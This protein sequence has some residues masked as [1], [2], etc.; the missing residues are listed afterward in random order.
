MEQ[1]NDDDVADRLGTVL[2]GAVERLRRVSGGASRI[3][4]SFD[5][6]ASDG[7]RRPLILQQERGEHITHGSRVLVEADLLKAAS[8][9]GVPVPKVVAAGGRLDPGWLVV[10]RL[11]GESIPRKLLRDPEWVAAR[12]ALT[13]QCGAALAAIHR[14]D[15]DTIG[16]LPHHDP[17][18]DPLPVLDELGEI[19]PTLGLGARWLAINRLPTDRR[20][21]VHGDFRMG[22]LLVG[23]EGLRAV[24]DWELAH[25]GD[26]AED[27]GWL[28]S[29]AWRFGGVGR[30]GGFGHLPAL[31]ESY[32]AA[33]GVAIDTDRIRWWEAYAAVKWAV[34]C[35][36][37][38][39][40][41]LRG[42]T[43]SM[44]LA[45]IGRR[46]C[47]SEWDLLILL[48]MTPGVS[49]S[50]EPDVDAF[51]TVVAPFGRP[52]AGEL[53][54]AVREHL[55]AAMEGSEGDRARFEA[56]I[57][58]NILRV[59]ERELVLGPA[60]A[61]AHSDRLAALGFTGDAALAASIR[62][63]DFDHDLLE[64]GHALAASTREQLLVANPSYLSDSGA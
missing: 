42:A 33:G 56:R 2:G 41:H 25:V 5:L 23:P 53:V 30:V 35:A 61:K 26:P 46:V 4:S 8:R 7:T 58:R 3:T 43:R 19:R 31:L 13:G 6:V 48:G 15:P 60:M 32:A 1:P 49:E 20:V 14:I 64:V 57:G 12:R 27:I 38:A 37:Q 34:I 36:L 39:S 59:V 18:A 17:L 29:R 21:T 52:S 28:C 10:E 11:E 55:E 62:S 47:E 63:G 16:G 9:A 51:P 44:E 50:T 45:A 54:E 22:N 40:A 24:L